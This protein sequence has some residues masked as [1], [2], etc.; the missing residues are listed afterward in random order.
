MPNPIDLQQ[1]IGAVTYPATKEDIVRSAEAQGASD[2]VLRAIRD[3]PGER[4]GSAAEV[5]EAYGNP[6]ASWWG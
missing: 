5:T 2:D 4:F 6:E 1:Y 3:L